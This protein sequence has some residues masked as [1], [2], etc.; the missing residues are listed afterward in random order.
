MTLPDNLYKIAPQALYKIVFSYSPAIY[1]IVDKHFRIQYVN[2]NYLKIRGLTN[3]DVLGAHCYDLTNNGVHCEHCVVAR[4][5]ASGKPAH[6]MRKDRLPDGSLRYVDDYAVPLDGNE[7]SDHKD[8][9]LEIVLDRTNETQAQA[10]HRFDFLQLIHNLNAMLEEK[11]L[12]TARHSEGVRQMAV[13]I[14]REMQLSLS[15][16]EQIDVASTLHD[17]GKVMIDKNIINK[18][19]QL[20]Y[21]EF[22]EIRKHPVASYDI[23]KN[24]SQF[25][26]IKEFVRGHHE[27]HDGAGY[28]DRLKGEDIP[29]GARIIAVADTYDA[30]TSTRSYRKALSHETAVAEIARCSGTQF[31]PQVVEAFLRI[32]EQAEA[33]ALATTHK[34]QTANPEILERIVRPASGKLSKNRQHNVHLPEELAIEAILENSPIAYTLIDNQY[35]LLY[36]SRHYLETFHCDADQVKGSPCYQALGC[37]TVCPGCPVPEAIRS[38]ESQISEIE[39]TIDGHERYFDCHAIPYGNGQSVEH[40]VVI[41]NDRTEE[42]RTQ[43]RQERDYHTLTDVFHRLL[44]RN[45][46]FSYQKSQHMRQLCAAL[47]NHMENI[48]NDGRDE[49]DLSAMLCDIGL[50]SIAG[51]SDTNKIRSHPDI[52]CRMLDNLDKFSQVRDMV[53]HHH[54]RFDGTGYPDGL[55]GEEI[56]LGSRMLQLAHAYCEKIIYG[57]QETLA[58]IKRHSGSIFDPVLVGLLLDFESTLQ[59]DDANDTSDPGEIKTLIYQSYYRDHV[60]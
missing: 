27:R 43:R 32:G 11:D 56:P 1:S 40:V 2:D 35:N 17:I 25:A 22:Q 47:C 12:Y 14:A 28:P 13:S 5:I 7:F 51:E 30:M 34:R 26:E 3:E 29:L 44:A 45:D 42:R 4:S 18:P 49:I 31:D 54:E 46:A 15:E 23:I 10:N 6:I 48:N 38:G 21:D 59:L 57:R 20:N 53:K 55:K 58:Y 36:A 52:A 41:L 19:G 50:I 9:Y 16:I 60:E 24:L 37:D 33:S 39:Q 8:Y